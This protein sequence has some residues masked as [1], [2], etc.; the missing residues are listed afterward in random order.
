MR[1]K[2]VL[3]MERH[4]IRKIIT[5]PIETTITKKSLIQLPHTNDLV[6]KAKIWEMIEKKQKQRRKKAEIEE[7]RRNIK[8]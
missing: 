7:K 5:R 3:E 4:H 6:S 8:D 1:L 2:F